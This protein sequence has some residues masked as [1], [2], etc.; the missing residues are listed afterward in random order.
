MAPSSKSPKA[1]KPKSRSQSQSQSETQAVPKPIPGE[2]L[3]EYLCR[4]LV[5]YESPEERESG[6]GDE[7]KTPMF[8]FC[9]AVKAHPLLREKSAGQALNIVREFILDTMIDERDDDFVAVY[10]E[11]QNILVPAFKAFH[12]TE[13]DL[14]IEF[15]TLWERIRYAEGETPL[16]CALEMARKYPYRLRKHSRVTAG[17]DRFI[18]MAAWLQRHNGTE[19]IFLPCRLM[20][21]VLGC[22][23]ITL[24][25]YRELATRAGLLRETRASEFH[26]G[27][28]SIATEFMFALEKFHEKTRR[29]K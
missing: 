16:Y 2:S 5:S 22:S 26:R 25:R 24:S 7:W 20:A 8:A 3:G 17:Y 13:E 10:M 12:L 9:R 11:T 1:S 28:E 23:A 27:G 21:S 29:E 18:S 14:C 6:A 19:P 4:N 15:Y